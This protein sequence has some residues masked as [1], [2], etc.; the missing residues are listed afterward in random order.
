MNYLAITGREHELALT[1]LE[2]IF[3]EENVQSVGDSAVLI[4]SEKAP[5]QAIL[6][7]SLK[8]AKV[9]H[10]VESSELGAGF[11]YLQETIPGQLDY[12]PEGKLQFGVSVY[13]FNPTPKWILHQMLEIKK[14]I[15]GAGRSVRIIQNKQPAL[16]SAQVLYN[17][18]TSELGWELLL[19]KNGSKII[20]AQTLSVQ[21][22]DEYAAR[23]QARPARNAKVGMLPPK[24]AQI[25]LNLANPDNSSRAVVADIF[26]GS[27][28]VLQEALLC[29]FNVFGSDL[30]PEMIEASMTNL[31]WLEQ[32]P[33]APSDFPAH[34][35]TLSDARTAKLPVNTQAIVSEM[36][37][38]EPLHTPPDPEKLVELLTENKQLLL[39]TLENIAAQT[40]E[41]TTLCIAVPAWKTKTVRK[42]ML[43]NPKTV[44]SIKNLGYTF[45]KFSHNANRPLIYARAHQVVGRQMLVIRRSK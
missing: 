7:G 24:L 41:N 10:E 38:G 1:E 33:F 5:N 9:L 2:A 35:L 19:V 25:M 27:G 30:S 29:G 13:G 45:T 18:L 21:D 3:G 15:R 11:K 28:V 36:Y 14:L 40:S 44:E 23:D 8:I 34:E 39:E 26:C 20:L 32:Q 22:I 16:L 37:L 17:K 6:G 42:S 12:L 4:D 31:S 43:D